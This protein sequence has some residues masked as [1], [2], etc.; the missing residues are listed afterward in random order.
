MMTERA[1]EN[2][3][4]AQY[5]LALETVKAMEAREA[6]EFLMRS[7]PSLYPA[8]FPKNPPSY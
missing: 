8:N 2:R 5:Q 7:M 6:F 1:A 3:A 4:V